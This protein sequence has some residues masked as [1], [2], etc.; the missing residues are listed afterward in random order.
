MK[1]DVLL[2]ENTKSLRD[3]ARPQNKPQP[4]TLQ[5]DPL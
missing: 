1:L 4:Q 5:S 3:Y 2:T